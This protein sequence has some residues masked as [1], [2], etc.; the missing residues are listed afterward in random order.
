MD[1]VW[2]FTAQAIAYFDSNSQIL[3]YA[4][5]GAMDSMVNVDPN[6]QLFV[7]YGNTLTDLGWDYV[8]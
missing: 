4:P 8:N 3:S 7:P 5:F 6:N 2:A 1:Q